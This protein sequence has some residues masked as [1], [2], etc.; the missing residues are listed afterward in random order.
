MKVWYVIL[1][2]IGQSPETINPTHPMTWEE[3]QS[4]LQNYTSKVEVPDDRNWVLSCDSG[5]MV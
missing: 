5:T 1:H 4:T 3:C 2:V